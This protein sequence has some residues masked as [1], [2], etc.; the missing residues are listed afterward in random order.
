L[1]E[2]V[3]EY[4]VDAESLSPGEGYDGCYEPDPEHEADSSDVTYKTFD[5]WWSQETPL[6]A[7]L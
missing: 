5:G 1:P 2:S 6:Y 4:L 3:A 7:D